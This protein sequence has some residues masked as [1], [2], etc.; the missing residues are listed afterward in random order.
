VDSAAYG[1]EDFCRD[2]S[3]SR[4]TREALFTHLRLLEAWA[5]RVNLIGPGELAQYWRRHALD[6][7][8]LLRHAPEALLWL[9]LGAGAGFPG[10]VIA[11]CL[12]GRP[13]ALVTLVEPNQKRAA[14]LREAIRATGAPAEVVVAKADQ[15]ARQGRRFDVVTA[16]AF[17][18][19]ARI[20]EDAEPVL[21]SGAI[22]LFLKGE[23]VE[24]ELAAA[25]RRWKLDVTLIPS[26][27]D[28]RGRIV[29]V[30]G[31]ERV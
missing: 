5:P 2:I 31:A 10:L 18:P 29:R 21:Q 9:D 7:A 22:G 6:S 17:A 25:R 13:D 28:P 14:F 26:L 30:D 20:I 24:A 19:L 15:V 16:R 27:S 4:E 12:I 8:Q 11:C 1:S 3:V 23:G